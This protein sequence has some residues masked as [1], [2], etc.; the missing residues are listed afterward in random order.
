MEM[1]GKETPSIDNDVSFY[2]LVSQSVQKIVPV[3]IGTEYVCPLD[4]PPHDMMQRSGSVQP[5]LS[6]HSER[7][8]PSLLFVKL[9]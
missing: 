4:A 9:F 6:R 3:L 5:R 2:A 1:V 8:D 7:L